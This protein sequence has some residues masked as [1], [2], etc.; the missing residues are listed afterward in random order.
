MTDWRDWSEEQTDLLK[1]LW[2]EGHSAGQIALRIHGRSRSAV[3]GKV[4]R[5]GLSGRKVV[6]RKKWT[7]RRHNGARKSWLPQFERTRK[8]KNA[9][10][11]SLKIEPLPAESPVDIA[12]VSLNGLADHHCRF[13]IGDPAGKGPDV[14]QFCGAERIA[15]TSYCATHA[16]RCYALPRVHS[17]R[18]TEPSSAGAEP[19]REP[20]GVA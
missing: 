20:E 5:L 8:R 9:L 14:K 11:E 4:H 19:Q 1:K 3:I 15:G 10:L 7:R 17:D 12:R 18:V 13:P 16:M 2:A 6:H